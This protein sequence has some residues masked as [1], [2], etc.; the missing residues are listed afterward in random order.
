MRFCSTAAQV[1]VTSARASSSS[2]HEQNTAG[3]R[4][5]TCKKSTIE[6]LNGSFGM[7]QAEDGLS[8]GVT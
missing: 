8:Q 7:Q 6:H 3:A 5:Q 1:P 2:G 4:K